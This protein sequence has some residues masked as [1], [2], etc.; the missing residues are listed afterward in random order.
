MLAQAALGAFAELDAVAIPFEVMQHQQA[1]LADAG[2]LSPADSQR[3]NRARVDGLLRVRRCALAIAAPD[4]QFTVCGSSQQQVVV[5]EGQR[6]GGGVQRG[7][8]AGVQLR[9]LQQVNAG[10]GHACRIAATADR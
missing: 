5:T 6:G 10:A 3:P 7:A 9:Q 4:Q 1:L 8:E 2:D